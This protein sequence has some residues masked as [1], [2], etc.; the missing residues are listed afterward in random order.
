VVI[1]AIARLVDLDAVAVEHFG[2]VGATEARQGGR[3]AALM[4]GQIGVGGPDAVAQ[5]V[6]GLAQRGLGVDQLAHLRE[7]GAETSQRPGKRAPLRG[8]VGP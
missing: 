5:K 2:F 6:D 1:G 7:A 4:V 3:Q 8:A